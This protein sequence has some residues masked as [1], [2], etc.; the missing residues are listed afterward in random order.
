MPIAEAISD[1]KVI[2]FTVDGVDIIPPI[3]CESP[4]RFFLLPPMSEDERRESLIRHHFNRVL[5]E[6][7]LLSA[8]VLLRDYSN[9]LNEEQCQ[10][11]V[12][13]AVDNVEKGAYGFAGLLLS[14]NQLNPE[15]RERIEPYVLACSNLRALL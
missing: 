15:Q 3:F 13:T 4:N 6:G 8:V 5:R 9:Q 7:H 12:E 11:C 1:I 2:R 14:T 10:R